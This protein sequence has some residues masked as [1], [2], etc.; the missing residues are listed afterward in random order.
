VD[1]R[2]DSVKT[3]VVLKAHVRAFQQSGGDF[4]LVGEVDSKDWARMTNDETLFQVDWSDGGDTTVSRKDLQEF[5]PA[6][7][8]Q[9][10][11]FKVGGV[12]PDAKIKTHANGAKESETGFAAT[13]LP[14]KALLAIAAIQQHGDDKYGVGNWRDLDVLDHLNHAQIHYLA[15]MAGDDS[16][17]HLEH[18]ATRTLMALELY[19][20]KKGI[21]GE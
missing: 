17:K 19:L 11:P 5:V 15:Y 9:G 21:V 12:G 18:Y 13:S 16:D 10:I 6:A 14:P 7:V 4:P 8:A 1:Q 3:P 20:E 2:E